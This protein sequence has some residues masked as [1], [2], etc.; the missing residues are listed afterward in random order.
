MSDQPERQISIVGHIIDGSVKID[1]VEEFENVLKIFPNAPGLHRAFGDLLAEHK[2]F[3]SAVD[4]YGTAAKLFADSGSVLQAMVSMIL[5]WLI[6]QPSH[7]EAKEF[8][9]ALRE[10]GSQDV[11]LQ[12]F[13]TRMSYPELV[14]FMTKLVRVRLP[15]GKMVKRFGDVDN[16]LWFVVSGALK[17]TTYLPLEE[18]ENVHRKSSVDLV[19]S[20]FFGDV[21]PFEEEKLSQSEIETITPVELVVISKPRLITVCNKYPN[22]Q[23][24]VSALYKARAESGDRICRRTVRRAPRQQV[25][26]KVNMKIYE[27]KAGKES[28]V[29]DGFAEDISS[30]GALVVFSSYLVGRPDNVTGRNVEIRISSPTETDGM[31]ILGKIVWAKELSHKGKTTAAVGIRFRYMSDRDRALLEQCCYGSDGE[32]NMMWSLWDS[33]V[34]E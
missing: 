29:V 11:P 2:S 13:L 8:Y 10:S 23:R 16:Y 31:S 28:L 7:S 1:S 9:L 18:G 25:P 21:Y 14:A 15:A 3:D 33:L 6:V 27:A 4:A 24:L 20:D 22:V 5:E 12:N 34:K 19:E 17:E 26:T 30:G 32:Q